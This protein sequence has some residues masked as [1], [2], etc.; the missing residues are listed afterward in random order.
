MKRD[1]FQRVVGVSSDGMQGT[2]NNKLQNDTTDEKGS[3]TTH[4][5]MARTRVS[6]CRQN[7]SLNDS[8][9]CVRLSIQNMREVSK[10]ARCQ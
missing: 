4:K 10:Y 9:C 7:A 5:H 1:A 3:T 8:R 2:H 6:D